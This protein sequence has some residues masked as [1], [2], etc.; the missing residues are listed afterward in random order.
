VPWLTCE[1]Q[2]CEEHKGD[3]SSQ[4]HRTCDRNFRYPHFGANALS[5]TPDIRRIFFRSR[6]VQRSVI[7]VDPFP[8]IRTC[9][10]WAGPCSMVFRSGGQ[11]PASGVV[12]KTITPALCACGRSTWPWLRSVAL[13]GSIGADYSRRMQCGQSDSAIP[14]CQLLRQ[15]HPLWKSHFRLPKHIEQTQTIFNKRDL[16]RFTVNQ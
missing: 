12:R 15:V 14:F 11:C 1:Q 10:R 13:L 9:W 7:L 2:M 5:A 8:N 16:N 6:L 4:E 3:P